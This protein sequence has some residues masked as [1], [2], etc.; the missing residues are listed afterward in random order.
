MH[1]RYL[2]SS[3]G[4]VVRIKRSLTQSHHHTYTEHQK[5]ILKSDV[6]KKK[7]LYKRQWMIG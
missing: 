6:L 1:S 4:S 2:D 5:S 3:G 7:K